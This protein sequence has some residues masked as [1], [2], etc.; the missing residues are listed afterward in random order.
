MNREIAAT[1]SAPPPAGPYSQA[2]RSGPM[3]ALAGQGGFDPAT[4]ELAGPDFAAEA[5]RTFANLAAVLEAAGAGPDNVIRLGVFLT[6]PA[7]FQEMNEVVREFFTEPFPARTTVYVTLPGA[8]RIE[9][10]ALAVL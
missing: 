4:R 1:D 3:L 2:V 6:D 8:M 5:R 7:H 9:V 10:D